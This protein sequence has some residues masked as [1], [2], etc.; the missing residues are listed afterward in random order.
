MENPHAAREG[1]MGRLVIE[2]L[3]TRSVSAVIAVSVGYGA[4]KRLKEQGIKVYY[5][6]QQRSQLVELEKAIQMYL[7]NELEEAREPREID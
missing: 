1:G 6:P 2:F 7:N 3:R 4:F 5:V